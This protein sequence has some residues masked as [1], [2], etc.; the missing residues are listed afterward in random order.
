MTSVR[1][2]RSRIIGY[3]TLAAIGIAWAPAVVAQ[4]SLYPTDYV[5]RDVDGTPLSFQDDATIIEVLRDAPVIERKLMER[6]V[7]GN[8]GVVLDHDGTRIRAAFR[9]VDREEEEETLSSRRPATIRDAHIFEAAAY[10]LDRMLGIGR[11]PPTAVR[12]MGEELGTMQIWMEGTTP[13]DVLLDKDRLDPPD[14][15]RW[16][17]QK[18]IMRV[19]DALIAN[20][21]RNQGNLL[22]DEDWNIWFIDHTRAFRET[23]RLLGDDRLTRCERRLWAALN[24]ADKDTIRERLEPHLTGREISKL[25]LRHKRLLKH[26]EKLIEKN[27]E[28]AVLFDLKAPEK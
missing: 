14:V 19:F 17:Q 25:V 1:L 13:E 6:G 7:A 11:V 23:S 10:E 3:A 4:T 2:R 15:E 21:D 28:D 12:R 8:F 24:A 5:Y 9:V 20:T 16:H 27:G 18:A 22:I 26:F